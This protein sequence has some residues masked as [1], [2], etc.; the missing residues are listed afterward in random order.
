MHVQLIPDDVLTAVTV[1]SCESIKVIDMDM[2]HFVCACIKI[3]VDI[4]RVLTNICTRLIATFFRWFI[5]EKMEYV[6]ILTCP[7]LIHLIVKRHELLV[8]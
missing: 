7:L 3:Y 1:D 5:I 4:L 6:F 8:A 2:G